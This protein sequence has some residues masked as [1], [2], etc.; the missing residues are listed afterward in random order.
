MHSCR[1]ER[2]LNRSQGWQCFGVRSGS[3]AFARLDGG[4]VNRP[5][6]AAGAGQLA[7][8]RPL[9]GVR[10]DGD[11]DAAASV[12]EEPGVEEG[13]SHGREQEDRRQVLPGEKD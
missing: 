10:E 6:P 11:E 13:H 1:R 5:Q 9:C 12:D 2:L 8:D 3:V 7:P 4:P